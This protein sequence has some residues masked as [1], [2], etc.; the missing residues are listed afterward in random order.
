MNYQ[1]TT[2]LFLI[3]LLLCSPVPLLQP[4]YEA[5]PSPWHVEN[6]EPRGGQGGDE[7]FAAADSAEGVYRQ[8]KSPRHHGQPSRLDN[9]HENGERLVEYHSRLS[10]RSGVAE[11]GRNAR[12]DSNTDQEIL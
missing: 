5:A 2:K 4:L 1:R 10:L 3:T 12:T 6:V 11:T 8:S 9:L 7:G